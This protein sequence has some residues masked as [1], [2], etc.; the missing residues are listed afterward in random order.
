MQKYYVP[1]GFELEK[2]NQASYV[3]TE[4]STPI[5]ELILEQVRSL[6]NGQE[7]QALQ[8]NNIHSASKDICRVFSPSCE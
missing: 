5:V 1:Q 4:S 8:M 6:K 7:G 2:W 3:C